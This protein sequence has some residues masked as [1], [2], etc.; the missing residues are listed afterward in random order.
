MDYYSIR[1][2]SRGVSYSS[3]C[4]S[5]SHKKCD[6]CVMCDTVKS[7]NHACIHKHREVHMYNKITYQNH[8]KDHFLQSVYILYVL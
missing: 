1:L 2:I 6:P 7:K 3:V 5:I 4:Y 8:N